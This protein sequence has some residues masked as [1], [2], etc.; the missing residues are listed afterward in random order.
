VYGCHLTD[1][2]LQQRRFLSSNNFPIVETSQ[3]LQRT[4]S[5]TLSITAGQLATVVYVSFPG[6]SHSRIHFAVTEAGDIGQLNFSNSLM[7][8][9][10]SPAQLM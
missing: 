8:V 2:S 4:T 10:G 9:A 3:V 7:H 5:Y 6:R 1:H